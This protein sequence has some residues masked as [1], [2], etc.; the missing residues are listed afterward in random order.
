VRVVASAVV[1]F[2]VSRRSVRR[3]CDSGQQQRQQQQ[4]CHREQ[5]SSHVVTV[6]CMF[7]LILLFL[8]GGVAEATP[9]LLEGVVTDGG[10]AIPP[11][12]LPG[13]L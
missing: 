13:P 11:T 1:V 12:E 10:V 4:D 9:P 5:P 2:G 3:D 6:E 7:I 8:L